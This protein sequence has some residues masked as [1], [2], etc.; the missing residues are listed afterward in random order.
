[1]VKSRLFEIF[2]FAYLLLSLL[3]SEIN[4]HFLK[5][6]IPQVAMIK[7]CWKNNKLTLFK[8]LMFSY[9]CLLR[10]FNYLLWGRGGGLVK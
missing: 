10:V 5:S 1:M 2:I 7:Y 6:P 3:V 9:Y 4:V 8:N